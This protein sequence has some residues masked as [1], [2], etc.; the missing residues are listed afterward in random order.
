WVAL[1]AS[2]DPLQRSRRGWI[3]CA[4]RAR[5]RPRAAGQQSR[6]E[7]K[8]NAHPH[9]TLALRAGGRPLPGGGARRL[10]PLPL[11]EGW[12]EGEPRCVH[13]YLDAEKEMMSYSSG[14]RNTPI[15]SSPRLTLSICSLMS[16]RSIATP[17]SEC[18]RCSSERSRIGPC[19]SQGIESWL[20]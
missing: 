2:A 19:V 6:G 11:G 12:G 18:P 7:Q 16:S 20:R 15:G 3:R 10:P 4:L 17:W 8:E 14:S 9:P 1:D 5:P 13:I